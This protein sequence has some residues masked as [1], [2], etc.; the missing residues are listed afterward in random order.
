MKADYYCVN[1]AVHFLA[2]LVNKELFMAIEGCFRKYR[3]LNYEI[4][5]IKVISL[6]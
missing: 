6:T 3:N 5:K 1:F 4:N 2:I